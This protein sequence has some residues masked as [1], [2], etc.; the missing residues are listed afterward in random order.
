MYT[1]H[2]TEAG[3]AHGAIRA[4]ALAHVPRKAQVVASLVLRP[5]PSL[6]RP[7]FGKLRLPGD[8][9]VLHDLLGACASEPASFL[10]STSSMP[11]LT[12][13]WELPRPPFRLEC[14][15]LQRPPCTP[16]ASHGPP[17]LSTRWLGLLVPV[18][19]V[20]HKEVQTCDPWPRRIPAIGSCFAGGDVR[21][22]LVAN[23]VPLF[24]SSSFV[25]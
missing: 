2:F 21:S 16:L 17:R 4:S 15:L 8:A 22:D 25:C 24:S 10:W 1:L 12:G 3:V 9:L 7:F 18:R 14:A 6:C 11:T 20:A 5:C 13:L 19:D 23:A